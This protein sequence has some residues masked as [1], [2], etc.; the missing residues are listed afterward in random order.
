MAAAL[1]HF[2]DDL[3][4][5]LPLLRSQG[6]RVELS[7]SILDLRIRLNA[8]DEPNAV[9]MTDEMGLDRRQA[10][11]LVR[12]STRASLILF[13]TTDDDW[14]PDIDLDPSEAEFDLIVPRWPF[15]SEWLREISDVVEQSRYIQALSRQLCEQAAELRRESSQARMKFRQLRLRSLQL[16]KDS[17]GL[18]EGR[19]PANGFVGAEREGSGLLSPLIGA[20]D[21]ALKCVDCSESFVFSAGEQLF[22]R[23][24]SLQD[25]S[26]CWKCRKKNQGVFRLTRVSCSRCGASTMV[27]FKP[28]QQRPVLCRA[29][30]KASAM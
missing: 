5:A 8:G 21:R 29:C 26:R 4:P 30:F 12:S 15:S 11:H 14:F 27:P 7:G 23:E 3:C 18:M 16:Q 10:I 20:R 19:T 22:F 1:L 17:A 2:G 28:T 13:R 25:P 6:Y 24:K 9:S